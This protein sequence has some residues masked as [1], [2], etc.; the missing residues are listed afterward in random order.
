MEK[1]DQI[2]VPRWL[3]PVDDG[4]S[5]LE[6]HAVAIGQGRILDMGPVDAVQARFEDAS[7]VELDQHV[8]IPGLINTHT[9]AAMT[10]LRG[11]ADDLP[12]ME[13]LNDHI[14]PVEA[15]WV[16]R[17]FVAAGT[18]LAGAEM[19]SLIHI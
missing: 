5:V 1:A 2:L 9:H 6:G 3:V 19:L 7:R 10:L 15:K 16:S 8:L 4:H 13:W 17:E 12:L 11:Y 18:R 14:W